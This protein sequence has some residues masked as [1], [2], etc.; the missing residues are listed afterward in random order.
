MKIL[1]SSFSK[2]I[3]HLM[4]LQYNVLST[5]GMHINLNN[6]NFLRQDL[7]VCKL[8]KLSFVTV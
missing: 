6:E 8:E 3:L 2:A 1:D 5:D 7:R 4:L